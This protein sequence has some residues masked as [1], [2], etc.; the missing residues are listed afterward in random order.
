MPRTK[1]TSLVEAGRQASSRYLDGYEK[2]VKH[3]IAAQQKLAKQSQNDAVKSIV[4]TQ[5]EL[6]R[7]VTS[8]YAPAARRLIS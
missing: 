2:F 4:D 6:T 5:A 3:V 7:Q 8:T 1:H